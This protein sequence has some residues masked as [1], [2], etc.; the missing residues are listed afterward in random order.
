MDWFNSLTAAFPTEIIMKHHNPLEHDVWECG[1]I[2]PHQFL[3]A[4][5]EYIHA[6]D[7]HKDYGTVREALDESDPD[8][9]PFD[10][11]DYHV[12]RVAWLIANPDSNPIELEITRD[13]QDETDYCLYLSDGNHRLLASYYSN[14]D[15]NINARIIRNEVISNQPISET[16]AGLSA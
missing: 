2:E 13:E 3:E 6:Y 16:I 4:T 9:N 8:Y 12:A 14:P 15:G 1:E 11:H 7:G 5:S 10:L